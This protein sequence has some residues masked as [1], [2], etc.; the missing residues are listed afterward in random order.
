MLL[1]FC[2]SDNGICESKQKRRLSKEWR[3]FR[4]EFFS[5]VW[6]I[7]E[8]GLVGDGLS[9]W[10]W[11]CCD[12]DGMMGTEMSPLYCSFLGLLVEET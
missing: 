7:S 3:E 6:R 10:M 12:N 11:C 5:R 2:T 4:D 1:K 9:L 8:A